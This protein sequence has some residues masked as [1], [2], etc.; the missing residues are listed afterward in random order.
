MIAEGVAVRTCRTCHKKKGMDEF[1]WAR[2]QTGEKH[3]VC[4]ACK[5]AYAKK[6]TKRINKTRAVR[7]EIPSIEK[8][9]T[10][11]MECRRCVFRLECDAHIWEIWFEPYCFITSKLYH[12]FVAEYGTNGN[13]KAS[14]LDRQGEANSKKS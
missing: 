13:E 7:P 11:W 10:V 12:R 3:S 9:D 5:N 14:T 1:S 2:K 6:R 4:K 8:A